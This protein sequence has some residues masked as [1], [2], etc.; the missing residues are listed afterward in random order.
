[1]LRRA[2]ESVL[3]QTIADFEC[4]VVD[5]ASDVPLDLPRDARIRLIRHGHRQGPAVAR[6]TA[7]DAASGHYVAFLDDDDTYLPE[8]LSYGL[9]GLNRAPLSLCWRVPDAQP[10]VLEGDI[11]DVVLDQSPPHLGQATV[12]RG[13][14]LPFD[15]RFPARQDVEWWLRMA[16]VT[17]VATVRKVGYQFTEHDGVRGLNGARARLKAGVFLMEL[18]ADY[19]AAHRRAHARRLFREAMGALSIGE[20]AVARDLL[21]RSFRR[22][23]NFRTAVHL[24]RLVMPNAGGRTA[25]EESERETP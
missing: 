7:L 14:V 8:R 15:E 20:N 6:N 22:S 5:D 3:A 23:P 25:A 24:G 1:M 9:E 19:F 4:I 18:H 2:V 12:E 16:H 11:R 21:A 10:R 17:N 13:L